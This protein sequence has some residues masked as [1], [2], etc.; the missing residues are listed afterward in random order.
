MKKLFLSAAVLLL[1]SWA[2]LF[3]TAAGLPAKE[4]IAAACL[5]SESGESFLAENRI[6]HSRIYTAD[7]NGK[8]TSVYQENR[9]KGESFSE[10]AALS[11]KGD[12]AYFVR[13][14]WRSKA[15]SPYDWELCRLSGKEVTVIGGGKSVAEINVTGLGVYYGD[16]A[17]AGI[18]SAGHAVLLTVPEKG[19]EWAIEAQSSDNAVN[20]AVS[21]RGLVVLFDD[22]TTSLCG[23]GTEAPVSGYPASYL[24]E[25]I[26]LSL[27]ARIQCKFISLVIA[28]ISVAAV[29]A[30]SFVII[31]GLRA[32]TVVARMTLAVGGCLFIAFMLV[33]VSLCSAGIRQYID[34]S[35]SQAV[36]QTKFRAEALSDGNANLVLNDDFSGSREQKLMKNSLDRNSDTVFALKKNGTE[37]VISG[38]YPFGSPL[39]SLNK[40]ESAAVQTAAKGNSTGFSVMDNGR[41]W[42]VSAAPI[43]SNG[44]TVAVLLSKI[45]ADIGCNAFAAIVR[46]LTLLLLMMFFVTVALAHILLRLALRPMAELTRQMRAVSDGDLTA[47]GVADRNDELGQLH[48]AM[49][50][51]CAGLSIRDYEVN[52]IIRSYK[53][54]IPT[55]LHQLLDRASVMEVSF[56]DS[57]SITGCISLYSVNNR[58]SA[59]SVLD[60]DAFVDFVSDCFSM[61]YEQVGA[62]NGQM[63]S[64]GF[65]LASIPVYYPKRPLNALD[66]GLELQGRIS[67]TSGKVTP[68]YFQMLHYTEFMYG[69]AG[70]EDRVFPFFS[71]GEIEFLS[72][73][74]DRLFS[75]GVAMAATDSYMKM[76]SGLQGRSRY[77]GFVNSADGKYSYKLYELLDAYSDIERTKRIRYDSQFQDAIRLFY[78]NDFYLARNQF[79]TLL[80]SCPNDGVARWYLF[81]C[82]QAFNSEPDSIDYQLFGIR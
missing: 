27:S 7:A 34:Q 67:R 15:L 5:R 78:H 8:I 35:L 43:K 1:C 52:S 19:G 26:S 37:T 63:L 41:L 79:S 14:H 71:S 54:F 77:I 58:D 60:D 80:K 17:V 25:S 73:F 62:H 40:R 12:T 56:G 59:R 50:E 64:N 30:A 29:T 3:L 47:S 55:A 69:I 53:R 20:A 48:D 72:S 75:L 45:P 6:Q 42:S 23:S 10:I 16:V 22:A 32:R 33:Y 2:I 57:N 49:Q 76:T 39:T 51:M 9:R 24:P 21:E 4:T 18:D 28:F 46:P 38:K 11:A 70:V 31:T 68:N 82:E 66:A 36:Y 13:Q 65:E 61:L 81:A 74:S 44:I